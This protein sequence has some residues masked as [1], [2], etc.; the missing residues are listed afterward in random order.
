[1]CCAP[2]NALQ[3]IKG[4]VWAYMVPSGAESES[5][6]EFDDLEGY[7]NLPKAACSAADLSAIISCCPGL[8]E[9]SLCIHKRVHLSPLSCLAALVNLRVEG[10]T[11]TS[12]QSLAAVTQLTRLSVKLARVVRLQSVAKLEALRRLSQLDLDATA[13]QLPLKW[14]GVKLSLSSV[15]DGCLHMV[16]LCSCWPLQLLVQLLVDQQGVFAAFQVPW[17]RPVVRAQLWPD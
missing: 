2:P 14:E 1:M 15:S 11:D 5:E 12:M 9:L 6:S 4:P 17:A 7:P 13:V 10:V 16:L 3:S 8:Q